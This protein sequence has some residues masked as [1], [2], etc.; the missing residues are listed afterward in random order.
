MTNF[1]IQKYYQN[2]P[3]FNGIYS[4]NNFPEIKDG[5]I[6]I[7]ANWIASYMNVKN[8]THFDSFGVEHIPKQIRKSIRT[9][10]LKQIFINYKH[11]VQ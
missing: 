5:H 8:L 4:R 1:E 6:S 2:K 3:K 11:V 9:K 10:M 7:R